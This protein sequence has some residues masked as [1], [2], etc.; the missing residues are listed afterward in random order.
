MERSKSIRSLEP[1]TSG[2]A[3]VAD[4]FS[5]SGRRQAGFFGSWCEELRKVGLEILRMRFFCCWTEL[6]YSNCKTSCTFRA[7]ACVHTL[8]VA[9]AVP[10]LRVY[11]HDVWYTSKV[12]DQDINTLKSCSQCQGSMCYLRYHPVTMESVRH[13]EPVEDETL[14]LHCFLL[15]RYNERASSSDPTSHTFLYLA[16]VPL[17]SQNCYKDGTEDGCVGFCIPFGIIGRCCKTHV[18]CFLRH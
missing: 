9:L 4:L 11:T 3:V 13:S 8:S 10:M 16:A 7:C 2:D 17:P 5:G 12:C 15:R 1:M 14:C 6:L 18:V